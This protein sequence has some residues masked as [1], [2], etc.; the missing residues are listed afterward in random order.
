MNHFADWS[1]EEIDRLALK[2]IEDDEPVEEEEEEQDEEEEPT[3]LAAPVS[4]DWRKVGAV[5]PVR[6]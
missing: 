6:N 5:G 3:T 4:V 2:P 1:Q